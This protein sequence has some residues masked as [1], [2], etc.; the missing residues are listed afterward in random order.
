MMHFFFYQI[1]ARAVAVY[2]CIDCGRKLWNGCITRRIAFFH[3]DLLE[4][5]FFNQSVS[6]FHRDATPVR[7]WIQFGLETTSMIAC[8]CVAI[9]GWNA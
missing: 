9:F 1:V 4:L 5:L 2:F 6:I 7:F 8:L 3:C